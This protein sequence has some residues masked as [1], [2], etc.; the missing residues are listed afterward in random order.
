GRAQVNDRFWQ[1]FA[2]RND[3][4][5][6]GCHFADKPHDEFVENYANAGQGSGQALIEA[7]VS[8]STLSDHPELANAPLLLWGM[9]AGGEFNYEFTAWKPERVIAFVVNKG[10]IYYSALLSREARNVPGILFI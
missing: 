3:I 8:F 4:A 7:L 5:L 9:S 1:D 10:G 6:I 2:N